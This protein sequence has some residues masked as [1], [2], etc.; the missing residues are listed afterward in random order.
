[1]QRHSPIVTLK[2]SRFRKGIILEYEKWLQQEAAKIL[3]QDKKDII[4]KEENVL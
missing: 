3:E 2:D 4:D 1:M